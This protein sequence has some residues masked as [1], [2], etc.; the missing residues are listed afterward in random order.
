[1]IY[2]A[3]ALVLSPILAIIYFIFYKSYLMI[4]K[5][6]DRPVEEKPVA[7]RPAPVP[8]KPQRRETTDE[9]DDTPVVIAA[10]VQIYLNTN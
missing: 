10:A 4:K 2:I 3:L 5:G 9:P 7:Y 1:M 8:V 6:K